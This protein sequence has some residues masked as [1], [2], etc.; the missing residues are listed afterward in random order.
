M[1]NYNEKIGG[2]PLLPHRSTH[3]TPLFMNYIY[4]RIWYS[5]L[6]SKCFFMEE[7]PTND[8]IYERLDRAIS[9]SS[10]INVFPDNTISYENFTVSNHAPILFSLDNIILIKHINKHHANQA[11]QQ[12]NQTKGK[13][14]SLWTIKLGSDARKNGSFM[15]IA[16]LD[17]FITKWK[18]K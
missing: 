15:V 16:T 11:Y 10:F 18:R 1:L 8:T 4:Y 5:L 9:H 17:S 13:A 7:S 3:T 14:H 12:I 2:R 6:P